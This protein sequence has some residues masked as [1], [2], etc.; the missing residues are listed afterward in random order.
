MR[1]SIEIITVIISA[2]SMLAVVPA[3]LFT[4]GTALSVAVICLFVS[5]IINLVVNA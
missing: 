5:T 4:S 1:E 2:L 3:V